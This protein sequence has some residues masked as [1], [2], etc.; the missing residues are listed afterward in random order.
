MKIRLCES[1]GFRWRSDTVYGAGDTTKCPDCG[2]EVR[3][4]SMVKGVN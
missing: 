2:A 1:C 4:D 3:G